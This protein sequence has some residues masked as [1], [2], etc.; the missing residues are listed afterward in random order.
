MGDVVIGGEGVL[1]HV[2]RKTAVGARV[3]PA[4]EG[5][6]GGPL[7]LGPCLQIRA[8][9]KGLVP[10]LHGGEDDPLGEP[11]LD[12]GGIDAVEV[13]LGH[14]G[15]QVADAIGG[16]IPGHAHRQF[17]V[18]QRH[19]GVETFGLHKGFL[20]GLRVGD[21]RA[22]VHLG[23]GGRQRR[24]GDDWQGAG[25][26]MRVGLTMQDHVPGIAVIVKRGGHDLGGVHG[27]ATAQ[28]D[29]HIAAVVTGDL[30]ATPDGR[31][32]WVGFDAVTFDG[33]DPC[34]REAGHGP[35]KGAVAFDAAA[36]GDDQGFFA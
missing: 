6:D 32:S 13:G 8:V 4:V 24:H 31:D 3:H 36:A 1:D 11:V 2:H 14:M 18:D 10:P 7:H 35:V 16:L 19:L 21:D 15:D 20:L 30:G 28:G 34:R 26:D 25:R 9:G 29:D 33:G 17:R 27:A 5:D 22:A 12:G 23:T